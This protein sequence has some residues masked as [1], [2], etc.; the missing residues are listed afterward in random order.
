VWAW[1]YLGLEITV[2]AP[3]YDD[4]SKNKKAMVDKFNKKIKDIVKDIKA[5]KY[6]KE[7]QNLF[8]YVDEMK[9]K[10]KIQVRK[11][12]GALG[13]TYPKESSN[14]D[15]T[16]GINPASVYPKID[17]IH[18]FIHAIVRIHLSGET[19]CHEYKEFNILIEKIKKLSGKEKLYFGIGD[20]MVRPEKKMPS[21]ESIA[22][23]I[24][25][26]LLGRELDYE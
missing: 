11:C 12:D 24:A 20:K 17:L 3:K 8:K 18:E 21:S 15:S 6:T 22:N 2:V 1:D 19:K 10:I 23:I 4:W 16:L 26:D 13:R 5:G 7:L 14:T 25:N 9:V